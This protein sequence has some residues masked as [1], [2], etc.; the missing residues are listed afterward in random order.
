MPSRKRTKGKERKAKSEEEK[1]RQG[2][3]HW[4]VWASNPACDHG[5]AD[6]IPAQD[7]PVSR[8]VYDWLEAATKSDNVPVMAIMGDLVQVHRG[9]FADE[10]QRKAACNLL[11]RMATNMMLA[12]P[13]EVKCLGGTAKGIALMESYEGEMSHDSAAYYNARLTLC[14]ITAG[15]ETE[16]IRFFAKRTSCRC[17]DVQ[18]QEAKRKQPRRAICDCCGA[19]KERHAILMC[20]RCRAVL[21]W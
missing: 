20:S 2:Y 1:L 8:L 4:S 18:Y 9:V 5:R 19:K 21:Y 3:M 12:C 11:V 10:T 6:A 16:I 17:L 14:D 13:R 15:A 7:N